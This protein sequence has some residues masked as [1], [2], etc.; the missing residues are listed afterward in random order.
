MYNFKI[1]FSIL[2]VIIICL[3]FI[4]RANKIFYH[5]GMKSFNDSRPKSK[6]IYNDNE[7]TEITTLG[8][9]G[10]CLIMNNEIQLCN[11]HE[12]IYHE[13]IVHFPAQYVENNLENVFI[14][15]GGDLMTLREVMKYPNIKK[16]FV[17]ELSE[18]VVSLSKEY[19]DQS[20]YKDDERVSIIYGD[21]NTIIDDFKFKYRNKIDLVIVDTTED[22]V[23]NTTVDQ[24]SFFI[25]CFDLLNENGILV[26]N[27]LFFKFFFQTFAD[28]MTISYNVDIP[29]FQEKYNFIVVSKLVNNIRNKEIDEDFWNSKS[30]STEFYKVE[31]HNKYI[32]YEEYLK[33]SKKKEG[34]KQKVKKYMNVIA[35]HRLEDQRT[36]EHFI[37]EEDEDD[38]FKDLL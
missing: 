25:K 38:Q 37:S 8:K 12:H 28:L 14:I 17:L 23:N 2:F 36:D 22:N 13:M 9:F 16:V 6:T 30:I 33:S 21:A 29:Y 3:F 34:N 35:S 19:F 26:K 10:K 24:P 27:G 5:E 4:N 11:K 18:D 15:G 31:D 32:I 1:L 7:G 20:D